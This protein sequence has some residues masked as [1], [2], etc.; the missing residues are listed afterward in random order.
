METI[1]RYQR[2]KPVTPLNHELE[3]RCSLE[4]LSW[5]ETGGSG[6]T[7]GSTGISIQLMLPAP[8][9]KI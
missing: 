4:I 6:Q 9:Q 2:L 1:K 7:A 3:N 5:K 8:S